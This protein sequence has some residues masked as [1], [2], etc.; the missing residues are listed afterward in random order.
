MTGERLNASITR[1]HTTVFGKIVRGHFCSFFN[2]GSDGRAPGGMT[3]GPDEK[4]KKLCH[5]QRQAFV[6]CM[7]IH[8]PCVQSGKKPFKD[9]LEEEQ[10]QGSMNEDCA[11]LFH[12]F[13]MCR[14]QLV[15]DS[16]LSTRYSCLD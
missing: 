2:V 9:C 12:E 16:T 11:K 6:D 7:F 14:L 5:A 1:L 3:G 4:P 15:K 8:S 10:Q 13:Q